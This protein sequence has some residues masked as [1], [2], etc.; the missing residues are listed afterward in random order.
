[1]DT[2][3]GIGI[4][5]SEVGAK[6]GNDSKMIETSTKFRKKARKIK[7]RMDYM[8]QVNPVFER[9]MGQLELALLRGMEDATDVL[10][11]TEWT[12][13]DCPTMVRLFVN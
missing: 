3:D 8:Q 4:T 2:G 5:S 11:E 1:M 7:P 13:T 12:T 10:Q 6:T 9:L